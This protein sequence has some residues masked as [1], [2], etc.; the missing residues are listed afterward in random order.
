[1]AIARNGKVEYQGQ[2]IDISGHMWMDGMYEE[3][4]IVWDLEAHEAK[5]IQIGYWGADG[6]NM[7]G[8]C[9]AEID[10]SLEVLRDML[11]TFKKESYRAFERSVQ[12][13]KQGIRKGSHAEVVKGRKVKK[14]TKLEVF[15]VGEKPT[16]KSRQ[17]SYIHETETIAGCYDEDGNKV[18]IKVEYLQTTDKLASPNAKERSKFIKAFV[19]DAAKHYRATRAV[20]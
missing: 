6:C 5:N 18:W 14:G 7:N 4:A 10:A 1:M 9:H 2:V 19:K 11:R 16:W 3:W 8:D 12:E 17:Y 15:W 20:V 13:Y